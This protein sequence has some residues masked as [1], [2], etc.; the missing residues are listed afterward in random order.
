MAIFAFAFFTSSIFAEDIIYIIQKGDTLYSLAKKYDLTVDE[1]CAYNSISNAAKVKLGQTIRIPNKKVS[2]SASG[3]TSYKVESGDTLFSIAKKFDTS[4]DS[5]RKANN[6]TEKSVL[7]SGKTL[8]IPG[9]E[10]VATFATIEKPATEEKENSFVKNNTVVPISDPRLY[11][12]KAVD[13]RIAWPIKATELSYVSGKTN[14]VVLLGSKGEDV[15]AVRSGK[16]IFSGLFRGSGLVV[17]IQPTASDYVYVYSG[18]DT[19]SVQKGDSVEFGSILGTLG[20]DT[21]NQKPQLNFMV[22]KNGAAIDPAKA[23]RG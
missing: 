5:I 8:I 4:I 19:T 14:S 11:Q 3:A 17:F 18:L 7:M 23:P 21:L 12:T 20:I 16:V 6:M 13:S 1:I 10:N 9:K 22:F 15:T 2:T